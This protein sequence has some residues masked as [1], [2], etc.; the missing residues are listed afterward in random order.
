MQG[1][2]VDLIIRLTSALTYKTSSYG[3]IGRPIADEAIFDFIKGRRERST[4]RVQRGRKKDS[5]QG[6]KCSRR[7]GQYQSTKTASLWKGEC[8]NLDLASHRVF[9]PAKNS[10]RMTEPHLLVILI[11]A[12]GRLGGIGAASGLR[13]IQ[14]TRSA[15]ACRI[16]DSLRPKN[17]PKLSCNDSTH[18]SPGPTSTF[19]VLRRRPSD[20]EALGL[21]RSV[22]ALFDV[23]GQNSFSSSFTTAITGHLL[24]LNKPDLSRIHDQSYPSSEVRLHEWTLAPD[25]VRIAQECRMPSTQERRQIVAA[26]RDYQEKLKDLRIR[27]PRG[28]GPLRL[29]ELR[30]TCERAVSHLISSK[31]IFQEVIKAAN[32]AQCTGAP[33]ATEPLLLVS[34]WWN[35]V[36]VETPL[37]WLNMRIKA[38]EQKPESIPLVK[39]HNVPGMRIWMDR[40]VS[41]P[42]NLSIYSSVKASSGSFFVPLYGSADMEIFTEIGRLFE[43]HPAILSLK[44]LAIE[45]DDLEVGLGAVAFPNV[46]SAVIICHSRRDPVSI[47]HQALQDLPHLPSLTQLVLTKTCTDRPH[48]PILGGRITW[49]QL[50][51][52]S[53][54]V[55]VSF[56]Q[57]R[58]VFPQCTSLVEGHFA[59]TSPTGEFVGVRTIESVTFPHLKEL[60]FTLNSPFQWIQSWEGLRFPA[61]EKLRCFTW[62]PAIDSSL[63]PNIFFP[64]ETLTHL[65]LVDSSQ[66][67]GGGLNVGQVH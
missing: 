11:V 20:F 37:L 54:N 49:S 56:K 8:F 64:L 51:H 13:G 26:R 50:T 39:S 1:S 6:V 27:H 41:Y 7:N 53:L 30:D 34:R 58:K 40:L 14:C 59:L 23:S 10:A 42:W 15:S 48:E 32:G 4:T 24:N 28:R 2:W 63:S 33:S 29:A 21:C 25:L 57:W 9:T 52:L 22:H 65:C 43:G 18:E 62:L 38:Q 47:E 60:V 31:R 46:T 19:G 16:L 44:R 67:Q 45:A 61:L 12:R 55:S 35:S 36:A 3:I 17:L 5:R 66:S